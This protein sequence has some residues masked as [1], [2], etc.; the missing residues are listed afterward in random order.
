MVRVHSRLPIFQADK[1]NSIQDLSAFWFLPNVLRQVPS[2][3]R[4]ATLWQVKAEQEGRLHKPHAEPKSGDKASVNR[5][6][7]MLAW[8]HITQVLARSDQPEDRR[9]AEAIVR[10]ARQVPHFVELQRVR[11]RAQGGQRESPGIS[12]VQIF[13]RTSARS[14]PEMERQ[15]IRPLRVRVFIAAAPVP[16]GV[17]ECPDV[18]AAGRARGQA[19]ESRPLPAFASVT[20]D[21]IASM[22]RFAGL[23]PP[24]T[25]PISQPDIHQ[26][27]LRLDGVAAGVDGG[28]GS[29]TSGCW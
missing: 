15:L 16:A 7:A 26:T 20:A 9:L 17:H 25:R 11:Q 1:S 14:G 19:T 28:L 8:A 29:A 18:R 2:E 6:R 10:Y 24:L 27:L 21:R 5:T 22:V 3:G 12:P 4:A 13:P 23:R